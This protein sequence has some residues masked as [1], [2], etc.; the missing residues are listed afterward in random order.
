MLLYWI[1]P[2]FK[3]NMTFKLKHTH[4][5]HIVWDLNNMQEYLATLIKGNT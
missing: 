4:T 1:G 5:I 3:K 2:I